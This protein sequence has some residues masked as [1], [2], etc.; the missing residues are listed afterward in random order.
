MIVFRILEMAY[1]NA[2]AIKQNFS[3]SLLINAYL[4]MIAMVVAKEE[5]WI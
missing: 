4:Y 1:T 3:L 5:R 2:T